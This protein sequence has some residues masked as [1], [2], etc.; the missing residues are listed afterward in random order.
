LLDVEFA[1]SPGASAA[2]EAEIQ[3]RLDAKGWNGRS[4][5]IAIAPEFEAWVWSDSPHVEQVL[6][7]T[8]AQMRSV[9]TEH[10]WWLPEAAKPSR[11]KELLAAVLRASRHGPPS[12]A[13]FEQLAEHVGL[14]R[15]TDPAFVRLR[16]TLRGWFGNP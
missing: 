12:A 6:G 11:P 2:I 4:R 10:G 15:C 9:A 16:E 13:L 7:Q 8:H 5:V 1:G 3:G 14:Q